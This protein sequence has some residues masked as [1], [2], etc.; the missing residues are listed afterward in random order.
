[1]PDHKLA[2][3]DNGIKS[4]CCMVTSDFEV[5]AYRKIGS[6][7][8]RDQ[9][10]EETMRDGTSYVE[11][12]ERRPLSIACLTTNYIAVSMP[13]MKKIYFFEAKESLRIVNLL[14]TRFKPYALYAL[15]NG[16]FAVAWKS[17]WS[18]GIMSALRNGVYEEKI[19]LDHD[20]NGRVFK[21]FRYLAVDESRQ[22]VIQPC[23]EDQAVYCFD[24]RGATI[25][26]FTSE[27]LVFPQGVDI[28]KYGNVYVC[29]SRSSC[30]H[31]I[32]P[33]GEGLSNILEGIDVYWPIAIAFTPD[34][35]E[36]IVSYGGT[37]NQQ[38]CVCQLTYK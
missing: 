26:T 14:C 12:D 28:D 31:V 1:M 16:E 32:S 30:I 35:S 18:F 27:K 5:I 29:D 22:H 4:K 13:T 37:G 8:D 2:L 34:R 36:F 19:H 17:P 15:K 20:Q 10:L 24:Y 38:V 3:V 23:I 7:N 33:S 21:T 11:F 9:N 6:K 25:F